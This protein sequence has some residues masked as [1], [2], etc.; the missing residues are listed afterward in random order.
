MGDIRN[1][2]QEPLVSIG[3]SHQESDLGWGQVCGY[4]S[5]APVWWVKAQVPFSPLLSHQEKTYY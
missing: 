2:S 1:Y 3:I 5:M 4:V